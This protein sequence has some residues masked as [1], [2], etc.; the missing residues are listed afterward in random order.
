MKLVF[1]GYIQRLLES[2]RRLL[3]MIKTQLDQKRKRFGR[4]RDMLL[5]AM[6]SKLNEGFVQMVFIR[7]GE[8]YLTGLE[9][10]SES[11]KEL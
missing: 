6:T 7:R 11:K 4:G 5:F 1:C 10:V 2:K 8:N 9:A 3:E